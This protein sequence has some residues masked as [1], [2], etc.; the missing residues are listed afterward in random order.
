M[1]DAAVMPAIDETK[2]GIAMSAPR[3]AG[4]WAMRMTWRHLLFMHWPVDPEHV[5]SLLPA[6]LEVETFAGR[7]WVGLI[8]FLMENVRQRCMPELPTTRRFPEC[9]VRTYVHPR[10]R[11]DLPGVWFFTL[12]AS[13]RLAV[14]VARRFWRLNY[15]FGKL[16][17]ERVGEN[18]QYRVDRVD[19]PRAAMRCAWSIGAPMQPSQPGELR[20]FLTERYR[21]F[22]INRAGQACEGKIW[23]KPWPLREATLRSL[24]DQLVRAAGIEIDQAQLPVTWHS[25]VLD[26]EAWPIRRIFPSEP[27]P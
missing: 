25:D 27:R 9:N 5:Q 20:H 21:L 1:R 17:I 16:G 18:L 4:R 11:P 3:P 24:D 2:V 15:K 23:H 10:G 19:A 26:V 7:A 12:D 22:A 6:S 14:Q 13:S 8:P